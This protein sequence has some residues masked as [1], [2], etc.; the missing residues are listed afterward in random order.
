[1]LY[2]VHLTMRGIDIFKDILNVVSSTSH[3]EGDRYLWRHFECCI[4][5]TSPWGGEIYLKTF[6]MFL[7]VRCTWYNIQNVF[8]YIYPP[9]GEVYLIQH[10]KCLQIYLSPSWQGV[11]DTTFKMSSNISIPLMVRCTWYNIQNEQLYH[12]Y[13][14]TRYN[15]VHLKATHKISPLEELVEG[16][17]PP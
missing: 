1:M 7:T 15:F 16:R 4:K 10:S 5:Y 12:M 2:Q 14:T 11:L 13:A 3:H 17:S 8:K 9:H 6:W